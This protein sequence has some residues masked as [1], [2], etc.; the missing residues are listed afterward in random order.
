MNSPSFFSIIPATVRY[1]SI[2]G[3]A[4][5]LYGEIT[6]LCSVE[7]YCYASDEYFARF[8]QSTCPELDHVTTRSIRRWIKALIDC[9]YIER[10]FVY[11]NRGALRGRRL[12]LAGQVPIPQNPVQYPVDNIV[13]PPVDKN[14]HTPGQYCPPI[15]KD[16]RDIDIVTDRQTVNS[17]DV[18]KKLKEKENV[19]ACACEED[20]VI[21]LEENQ[22]A[23]EE[24][25]S[26]VELARGDSLEGCSAAENADLMDTLVYI[27]SQLACRKTVSIHKRDVRVCE[28][29]SLIAK[30]LSDGNDDGLLR[31]VREVY[32]RSLSG[33]I[34]N[35]F[36]Y[37]VS[38]L[39]SRLKLSV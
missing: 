39:Y 3:N 22:E 34:G 1:A 29:L 11:D 20:T 36:N 12:Y 4:K 6:A 5:L 9:H 30:A 10:V 33:D 18:S 14:V 26:A 17:D 7:G 8:F 35:Q 16:S 15:D 19:G 32:E 21:V 28:V 25:I 31:T 2:P 24:V 37:L 27:S 23:Y 13:H 38:A